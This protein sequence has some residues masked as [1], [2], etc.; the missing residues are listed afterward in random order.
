MVAAQPKEKSPAVSFCSLTPVRDVN[1]E[2]LETARS[3]CPF[4]D[5]RD[6]GHVAMASNKAHQVGRRNGSR[7][8]VPQR[9]EVQGI[10]RE[11]AFVEH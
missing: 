8:I 3:A 10:E 6:Y 4:R 2:A 7:S 9:V 5:D 11:H 1:P